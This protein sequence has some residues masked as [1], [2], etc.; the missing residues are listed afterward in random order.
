[1]TSST[2]DTIELWVNRLLMRIAPSWYASQVIRQISMPDY[3]TLNPSDVN[4][5]EWLSLRRHLEHA[6][7]QLEAAQ[8]GWQSLGKDLQRLLVHKSLQRHVTLNRLNG[9]RGISVKSGEFLSLRDWAMAENDLAE[10]DNSDDFDQAIRDFNAS[11]D[12]PLKLIYREWDGRMYTTALARLPEMGALIR[13]GN[14]HS[15]EI[16]VRATLLLESVNPKVLDHLRNQ[17]WWFILHRRPAIQIA[18]LLQDCGYPAIAIADLPGRPD[19]AWLFTSKSNRNLNR[20][21]LNL[22]TNHSSSGLTELG[23]YLSRH[24]YGFRNK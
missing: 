4:S 6:A 10:F 3:G 18:S 22:M 2:F 24:K 7:A 5:V 23:R 11:E 15:R 12:S 8:Q 20:V 14:L 19:M 9:V 21:V 16:S 1:M 13:Y 17:Y